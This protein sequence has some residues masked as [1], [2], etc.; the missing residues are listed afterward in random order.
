M[1]TPPQRS[2]FVCGICGPTAEELT[3]PLHPPLG[4][5]MVI[6]TQVLEAHE[7][8][9]AAL[10]DSLQV[11]STWRLPDGRVWMREVQSGEVSAHFVTNPG[12]D[13]NVA[14]KLRCYRA[15]RFL[16]LGCYT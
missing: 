2:R 4:G 13:P 12:D 15:G 11:G 10:E 3:S 9:V 6:R 5:P 7:V 16:L 8:T 14:M 1:E